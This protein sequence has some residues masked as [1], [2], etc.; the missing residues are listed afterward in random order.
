MMRIV[1]VLAALAAACGP[2]VSPPSPDARRDAE[3]PTFTACDAGAQCVGTATPHRAAP[4]CV[5]G[6]C[7]RLCEAAWADCDGLA[8][9]G[10]EVYTGDGGV[11]P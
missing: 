7:L 11:C 6:Q 2:V 5:Q 3:T 10:C 1:F 8:A 4:T 9:N